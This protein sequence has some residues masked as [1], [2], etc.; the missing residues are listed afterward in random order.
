MLC[1]ITMNSDT[2]AEILQMY[3]YH[4]TEIIHIDQ[5]SATITIKTVYDL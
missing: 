4:D 3:L 1:I 2:S 5:G